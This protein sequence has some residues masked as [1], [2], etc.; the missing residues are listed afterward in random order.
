MTHWHHVLR[1]QS[2][3]V[4][5]GMV[6][7]PVC[8]A[9]VIHALAKDVLAQQVIL[10]TA[11]LSQRAPEQQANAPL[12]TALY[13]SAGAA[14]EAF[15]RSALNAQVRSDTDDRPRAARRVSV[16]APSARLPL[17]GIGHLRSSLVPQLNATLTG[18]PVAAYFPEMHVQ[19]RRPSARLMAA[20]VPANA[21]S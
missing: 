1:S 17:I 7:R 20:I 12:L 11:L 6:A 14:L 8:G 15:Y 2:S 16:A 19:V 5:L 3:S 10:R 4:L 9:Q 13:T 21:I 18:Q